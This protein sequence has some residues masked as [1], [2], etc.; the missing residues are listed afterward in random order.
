M[1]PFNLE[2][3]KSGKPICDRLGRDCKF[4]AYVPEAA[5][6]YN[7]VCLDSKNTII[8]YTK[9]GIYNVTSD[10]SD[11]DLFMKSERKDGWVNVYVDSPKS[12]KSG[13]IYETKEKA[14]S[15]VS[16]TNSKYYIDTVKIEFNS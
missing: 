6:G 2:E 16:D 4:I 14:V 15:F 1:K 11:R 10:N 8:N 7:V 3:A 9:D 12:Y 5:S 13:F